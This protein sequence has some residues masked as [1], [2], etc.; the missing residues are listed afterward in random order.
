MSNRRSFLQ[1]TIAVGLVM[2]TGLSLP[3]AH[4]GT[5]RMLVYKS[6]WCGCCGAWVQHIRAAGFE[7]RVVEMEDLEAIKSRAGV[8][9]DLAG[10]HT[11][12]V[13]GY[14]IEGHVPAREI[15]RLLGMQPRA[16][17]L[18]VPGMPDG[19]PGMD[20]GSGRDSYEVV[21]FSSTGRSVFARY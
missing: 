10:C 3:K 13:D 5:P 6:P 7:A 4:A 14:V 11:A 16:I 2:T 9:T 12:L 8:T 1:N 15:K 21:L 17:G 19:S 18:A 20:Q